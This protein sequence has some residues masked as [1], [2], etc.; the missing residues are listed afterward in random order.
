MNERQQKPAKYKEIRKQQLMLL[1]QYVLQKCASNSEPDPWII[2]LGDFNVDA[3]RR[4]DAGIDS[5]EYVRM[6]DILNSDVEISMDKKES[7]FYI[8]PSL[9]NT[10]TGKVIQNKWIFR[11]I[12]K[13]YFGAHPVTFADADVRIRLGDP[14]PSYTDSMDSKQRDNKSDAS[15]W[16]PLAD[17]AKG[18]REYFNYSWA[19]VSHFISWPFL[20]RDQNPVLAYTRPPV[21]TL[22]SV[23]LS[24]PDETDP[25]NADHVYVVPKETIL[26]NKED[27]CSRQRIDYILVVERSVTSGVSLQTPMVQTVTVEPFFVSRGPVMQCSD[28]YGL[29][30]EITW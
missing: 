30:A 20:Q 9:S 21:M 3:R 12:V 24:G 11:D 14:P 10:C 29:S 6:M 2:I 27:W 15:W 25:Y 19:N 4:P 26:T 17:I 1:T 13:E 18:L 23:L 16:W 8:G 7:R 22:P 28:H 5:E